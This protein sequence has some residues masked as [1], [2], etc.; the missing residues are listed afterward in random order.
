MRTEFLELADHVDSALQLGE[1]ATC[2]L[3]AEDSD[4]VRLTQGRVRQPGSVSQRVLTLRLVRG[5]R[6]ATMELSLAGV[7]TEDRRRVD[8]ALDILRQRLPLL[9][10]DPFLLIDEQPHQVVGP[11]ASALAP[12]RDLVNVL[13]DAAGGRDLVGIV[14]SGAVGRGYASSHGARCWSESASWSADYCLV[15]STDRAVKDTAAGTVFSADALRSRVAKAAARV[16]VLAR[17][18]RSITPGEYRAFLAPAAMREVFGLLSWGAFGGQS[19]HT[20]TSPLSRF[21][22]GGE[23][24][25]ARVQLSEDTAGGLAPSFQADGFL[26]PASLPLIEDG[27]LVGALVSPRAGLE[28][29][30]P[31]NG[32]SADEQPDSLRLAPGDLPSTD[33]LKALGTGL[34]ISNLW[35]L[36]FS[37]R[38]ACRMTGMTRFATFWVEDGEVVAPVPVMRFDDTVGRMLGDSLEALT[39]RAELVPSVDTYFNR[40]TSSMRLPGALLSGL[41]LTL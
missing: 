36:N 9:P 28:L 31:H 18:A 1:V 11:D 8:E 29:G 23:R 24:L 41:R 4:F 15:H 22:P 5:K 19:I 25:D 26:R 21:R 16:E 2:W 12:T 20:G 10:E 37:D 35:Y 14:A 39:D 40:S 34:W 6:H 27:V 7:A 33:T 3:S 17:P 30:I 38:S 32:A 13:L